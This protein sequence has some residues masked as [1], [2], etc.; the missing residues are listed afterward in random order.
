MGYAL[1]QAAQ[2]SGYGMAKA[3]LL[4]GLSRLAGEEFY[5]WLEQKKNLWN[6]E[7][8]DPIDR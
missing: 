8:F 4:D 1:E 7:I 2:A 5:Q 3:S 6:M